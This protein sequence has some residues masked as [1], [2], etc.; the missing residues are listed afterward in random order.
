MTEARRH[1][2]A[3]DEED[4]PVLQYSGGGISEGGGSTWMSRTNHWTESKRDDVVR[5]STRA[6]RRPWRSGRGGVSRSGEEASSDQLCRLP[7]RRRSPLTFFPSPPHLSLSGSEP[8]PVVRHPPSHL[9]N[10][11]TQSWV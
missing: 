5:W 7:R 11:L 3:G 1:R 10:R 8:T 4:G 9:T 2:L 6:R